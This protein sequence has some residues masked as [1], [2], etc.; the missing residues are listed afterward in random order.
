[1]SGKGRCSPGRGRGSTTPG[2]RGRSFSPALRQGVLTVGKGS[3]PGR[4]RTPGIKGPGLGSPV[5][6]TPGRGQSS[7]TPDRRTSGRGLKA[8]SSELRTPERGCSSGPKE[9]G[10]PG[11]GRSSG[12]TESETSGIGQSSIS[13]ESGTPGKGRGSKPPERGTS[14]R[15][16]GYETTARGRG[17]QDCT[18]SPGTTRRGSTTPDTARGT[19]RGSR[20]EIVITPPRVGATPPSVDRKRKLSSSSTSSAVSEPCFGSRRGRTGSRRRSSTT[21]TA[22][23]AQVK[24]KI[25]DKGGELKNIQEIN[26]H[27]LY[28]DPT[29]HSSVESFKLQVPRHPPPMQISVDASGSDP[30]EE[31]VTVLMK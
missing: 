23:E 9:S 19:I 22:A 28:F 30:N 1:M 27:Y 15:G 3:N 12:S 21:E 17:Q 6:N 8:E 14:T 18:G 2:R 29:L 4:G 11:R 24:G 10:T 26:R 7:D 16:R 25:Y 31:I 13:T 20:R 5:T